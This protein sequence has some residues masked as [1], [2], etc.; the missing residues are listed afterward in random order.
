ML[1]GEVEGIYQPPSALSQ[2]EKLHSPNITQVIK[3]RI[4]TG[5]V[6]HTEDRR[7]AYRVLVGKPEKN[8]SPGRPMRR[9]Q[10]NIKMDQTHNTQPTNALLYSQILCI[11]ISVS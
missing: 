5:H 9:W 6:A 8:R 10:N 3:S 4:W 7:G 1:A 11:T 2:T